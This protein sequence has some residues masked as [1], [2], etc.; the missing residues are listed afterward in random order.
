VNRPRSCGGSRPWKGWSHGTGQAPL[1]QVV[2]AWGERASRAAPVR[3]DRGD[4]GAVRPRHPD[5]PAARYRRRF[6][7]GSARPRST[8]GLAPGSPP[9]RGSASRRS[10][11]E[12]GASPGQRDP[13][14]RG[15]LQG[16]A[17]PPTEQMTASTSRRTRTAT[18][19]A[20]L[21]APADRPVDLLR[22]ED[23]TPLLQGPPGR[24][25]KTEIARVHAENFGVYGRAS[26]GDS[27]AGEGPGSPGAPW[28]G[29]CASSGSPA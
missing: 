18:G 1:Q 13:E 16:G 6:A 19:R 29:C 23:E 21:R 3:C 7:S 24:G 14:V 28:S 4:R 15:F 26:S 2:P 22:S 5:R 11:G 12:P 8:A 27:W 10:S 20:D 25:V 17:R 9:R